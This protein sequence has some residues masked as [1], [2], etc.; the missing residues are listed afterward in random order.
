MAHKGFSVQGV[1]INQAARTKAA[2]FGNVFDSIEDV[3]GP[4]HAITMWHVLEHVYDLDQ[5][6]EG[7]KAKMSDNSQP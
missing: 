1:E 5:L 6:L 7:F 2:K 4:V 3:K